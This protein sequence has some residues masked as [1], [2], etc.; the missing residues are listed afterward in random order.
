MKKLVMA[1]DQGTTSSRCVLYDA[2]GRSMSMAQKEYR[3]YYPHGGWVEHDAMEIWSSQLSC[4]MEAMARINVSAAD[5]ACIGITNQRETTIVWDRHTGEPVSRAICW[6]CRRTAAYAEQLSREGYGEMIREKTG[7]LPDAYFSGTKLKWILDHVAGARERAQR[8][9]LL[10]GTVDSWLIWKLTGGR[11]HVTDYSNASR[12]MMFNIHT[13]EWDDE[14]LDMLEIPKCMLPQPMPSSAVYGM[15]EENV[16]GASIPVSGAAGDQQAALFGQT[17]FQ[18]GESKMTF[19]TGGFM[20]MNT[21]TRPVDSGHGL[22]TTIAWGLDGRVNYALE[23]SVFMSGATV[24][25]LRDELGIIKTA[26]ETEEMALRAGDNGGVYL[27]PAHTGLGA[28]YWDPHARGTIFGLTRGTGRDHLARAALECQVY[29][30]YDL[31]KAMS[32]DSET[33]PQSIMVD[34]GGCLNGFTMQFLADILG[35]KVLLPDCI[36]TTSLGAAY[37]AG[38]ACGFWHDLEEIKENHHLEREFTP[39]MSG[40]NRDKLLQKWHKAVECT[41]LFTRS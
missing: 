4:A 2:Q 24:Q 36:E 29:Q 5:I 39:Q 12:T 41:M 31:L 25:W 20:L 40:E 32:E 1:F 7:L 27:V 33:S 6:Q 11:V 23:G 38:L 17:C 34:G 14:L 8:G 21:G 10:F 15:T 35:L 18:R 26:P 37:L 3:Q 22:L 9:D 16:I 30:T 13:L 28:P 19:G